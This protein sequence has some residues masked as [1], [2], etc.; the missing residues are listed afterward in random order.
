MSRLDQ[1]RPPTRVDIA[2]RAGAG[3]GKTGEL[4]RRYLE[5]LSTL[6]GRFYVGV[7]RLVAITFTEKAAGEMKSRL[8]DALTRQ[9]AQVAAELDIKRIIASAAN[10]DEAIEAG[11]DPSGRLLHFIRQRQSLSAAHISTI[12]AFCA[13][14]AREN[15]LRMGLAPGFTVIDAD[16]SS[17]ALERSAQRA[18]FELVERSDQR[19]ARWIRAI[20]FD[21][22]QRSSLVGELVGLAQSIRSGA[23]SVGSARAKY[24]RRVERLIDFSSTERASAF[25]K[26]K[27]LIEPIRIAESPA[28]REKYFAPIEKALA[29]LKADDSIDAAVAIRR[30]LDRFYRLYVERKSKTESNQERLDE[31]RQLVDR[32][33]EPIYARAIEPDI[34]LLLDALERTVALYRAEK[35][36]AGEVDFDDLIALVGH[37]LKKDPTLRASLQ[38]RFV[39]VMVD[40]FQDTSQA[41]FELIELLAPI[42]SGRLFIVGDLKQSIYRFN[43]AIPEIFQSAVE[44][45]E[46]TGGQIMELKTNYRSIRPIIEFANLITATEFPDDADEKLFPAREEKMEAERAISIIRADDPGDARARRRAEADSIARLIVERIDN[47]NEFEVFDRHSN[48]PRAIR[49]GDFG[50]LLRATNSIELYENVLRKRDIPYALLS[51]SALFERIEIKDILS[52]LSALAPRRFDRVALLATLRSPIAGFS[53]RALAVLCRS[54]SAEELDPFVSIADDRILDRLDEPDRESFRRFAPLFRKWR[55]CAGRMFIS[56]LIEMILT[57]S[58]Y[59]SVTIAKETG[60]LRLADIFRFVELARAKEREGPFE[61]ADFIDYCASAARADSSGAS[62]DI[63]ETS[64]VV[65]LMTIHKAKGLEFPIVFLANLA[66]RAAG[67]GPI[68]YDRQEGIDTRYFIETELEALSH[69]SRDR[70]VEKTRRENE[71]ESKSLFYVAATRARDKLFIFE[72]AR[73]RIWRGMIERVSS[74]APD[75]LIEHRLMSSIAEDATDRSASEA[76]PIHQ[77]LIESIEQLSDAPESEPRDSTAFDSERARISVSATDLAPFF[78]ST[79]SD[80]NLSGR[81]ALADEGG[82]DDG[83][84]ARRARD[85]GEIFHRLLQAESDLFDPVKRAEALEDLPGYFSAKEIKSLSNAIARAFKKE[86]LCQ[87]ERLDPGSARKEIEFVARIERDQIV[88]NLSA[89]VDLHYELDGALHVIDYKYSTRPPREDRYVNQVAIYSYI[90]SRA[91]K[92]DRVEASVVYVKERSNIAT[93]EI[94]DRRAL[95]RI[96]TEIVDAAIRLARAERDRVPWQS[97]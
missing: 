73:D 38:S 31:A 43:G 20:G 91:L 62:F 32:L 8:R 60:E 48:S 9:I 88:V 19:I 45:I 35:E 26:T 53:D 37:A 76:R 27:R 4:I 77:P 81:V 79:E 2:A 10:L 41:Q 15:P 83:Q 63:S 39:R 28:G 70:I 44:K 50:I 40:E 61:L 51:A 94:Y 86:P 64:D 54:D 12:H 46:Q 97:R 80:L 68:V 29:A 16:M 72:P 18:A 87:L 22:S 23:E 67:A 49:Y 57:D 55:A 47:P 85:L 5:E 78:G 75:G 21:R 95:E 52:A 93:T 56:E 33:V 59:I 3:S 69:P 25:E 36:R 84:R 34:G 82:G 7:D 30:A 14:L 96:E 24:R 13:R 11:A 66:E 71:N 42:G 58:D 1:T 17:A 6:D 89:V 90:L 74:I 92:I 65:K